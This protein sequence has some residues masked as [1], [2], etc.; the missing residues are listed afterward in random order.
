MASSPFRV[1]LYVFSLD[2]THTSR[3]DSGLIYFTHNGAYLGP[4]SGT[5]PSSGTSVGFNENA[6]LPFTPGK[7]YRLR[8]INTSA[9][10]TFAFWIDGHDMRVIE[11]CLYFPTVVLL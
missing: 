10:A 7:T 11:V 6:T 2:F 1:S 4:K 8:V 9:F 3:T 5:K